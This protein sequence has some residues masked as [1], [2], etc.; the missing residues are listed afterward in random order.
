MCVCVF[1][2]VYMYIESSGS[3]GD[4]S[5]ALTQEQR[6]IIDLLKKLKIDLNHQETLL[7][8]AQSGSVG[9]ANTNADDN[10]NNAASNINTMSTE[11][12]DLFTNLSKK[13]HLELPPDSA[14]AHEFSDK[15]SRLVELYTLNLG[16]YRGLSGLLWWLL[17]LLGLSFSSV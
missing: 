4:I 16:N 15:I 17:G 7:K 3:V 12:M 2:C 8:Q 9:Q 1:M 14:H 13:F 5:Q 10:P 11:D 6:D